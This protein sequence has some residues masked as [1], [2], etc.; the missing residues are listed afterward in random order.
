M[1]SDRLLASLHKYRT[2]S[3]FFSLSDHLPIILEGEFGTVSIP[4]PFKFKQS[5]LQIDDFCQ[6]VRSVWPTIQATGDTSPGLRF[7]LKLGKV[8]GIVT[9]WDKDHRKLEKLEISEI[10]AK[11]LSLHSAQNGGP[12]Q[13]DIIIPWLNWRTVT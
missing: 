6:F 5:L 11:I 7:A 12:I 9:K 4:Y 1:L 10:N 2:W 3:S 13:E 8:R